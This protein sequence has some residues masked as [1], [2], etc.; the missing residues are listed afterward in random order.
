[1]ILFLLLMLGGLVLFYAIEKRNYEKSEYFAQTGNSFQQVRR[2]KGLLGEYYIYK[3]LARLPGHKRFVFNC[4]LPKSEEEKTEVDVILIH[5]TGVYVLE[6]KN[7]SGWIFGTETNQY[8]TQTLPAGRGR[9]QKIHFPNPIIQNK[10]HL[11][12]LKA[13]LPDNS[14]RILSYI[15]FS[16]RCTLK[17]IN[18]TSGEH[19]VVKRSDLKEDITNSIKNADSCLN[20]EKIDEL[21]DMLQPLTNV[22]REEK[23]AHI[24]KIQE[25]YYAPRDIEHEN[26]CPV[27]GGKLILRT[28]TK[29]S[30]AG[31][32]FWG[33]SNYP[34]CKYVQNIE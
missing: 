3:R 9:S 33:C 27:C 2:D 25:K 32:Q 17:N 20:T 15:V 13:F 18:L 7:Y 29:G 31:K 30:R 26:K 4:Y 22:D 10:V 21:Y 5:E 24:H 34:K 11:K 23:E 16:E 28:A 19:R 6:S 8:W 1:M 12:W 14:L